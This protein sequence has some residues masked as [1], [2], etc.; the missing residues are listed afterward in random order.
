[1]N[2]RMYVLKTIFVPSLSAMIV[3]VGMWAQPSAI[4]KQVSSTAAQAKQGAQVPNLPSLDPNSGA[5]MFKQFCAPCHGKDGTGNGPVAS[6][7]KVPPPDLT[8]LSQRHEGKFPEAYVEDVLRNGVR[9]PAHGSSEM[10][11]WGPLFEKLAGERPLVNT[12]LTNLINYIK[13][14]QAN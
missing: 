11:V 13:S 10:P 7:L 3:T 1:M 4:K 6:E 8:A 14:L 9:N 12:L 2:A 5:E